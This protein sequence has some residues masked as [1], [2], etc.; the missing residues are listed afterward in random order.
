MSTSM[1]AF[2]LL[3]KLRRSLLVI[4]LMIGGVACVIASIAWS[5]CA[6]GA[7]SS[8]SDTPT[9]Y[10]TGPFRA[11]PPRT[12]R[13]TEN[14]IFLKETNVPVSEVYASFGQPDWESKPL[15][16]IAYRAVNNQA[17]YVVY[18]TNNYVTRYAVKKIAATDS[19][20]EMASLWLQSN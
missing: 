4:V 18:G 11:A 16:L 14:V 7:G 17:L 19:L 12:K 15:R 6:T 13:F 2:R 5:G 1:N 20:Q 10:P 9:S 3:P 8:N